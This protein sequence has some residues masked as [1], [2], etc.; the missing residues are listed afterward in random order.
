MNSNEPWEVEC[1][2]GSDYAGDLVSRRSISDFILYVL[3]VLVF[4]Q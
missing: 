4:W 2:R 1:F 3:G